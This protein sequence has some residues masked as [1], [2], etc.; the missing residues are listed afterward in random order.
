MKHSQILNLALLVSLLCT[1]CSL[2]S[3]DTLEPEVQQTPATS[4]VTQIEGAS[5][6]P[7]PP[8]VN[9]DA[10]Y[11]I[12]PGDKMTVYFPS[13]AD[14]GFAALVRPDGY[15]TLPFFGDQMAEGRTPEELAKAVTKRY[16]NILRDSRAVV[17]LTETGPQP[18]YIY[19]EVSKPNR[20][21]YS[22]GLDL[23]SAITTAGGTLRS[24]SLSNVI[25]IRVSAEGAY[26]Y[27]SHNLNDL[28]D[29]SFPQPVWLQP[30][31]NRR[32]ANFNHRRHWPLD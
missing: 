29:S 9:T 1:S 17:G 32:C 23:M 19:G 13:A 18:I 15:I 5:A 14:Y 30:R 28:L 27:Q 11:L 4:A 8:V 20:Y 6:P 16:S 22:R 31:D 7:L 25:V 10:G 3:R 21:V 2:R 26:T 24:A 12:Q